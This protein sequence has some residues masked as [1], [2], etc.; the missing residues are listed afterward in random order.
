VKTRTATVTLTAW[1]RTDGYVRQVT[2]PRLMLRGQWLA[3][4]GFPEGTKV[5][6]EV[7]CGKLIIRRA[8]GE[9]RDE[10]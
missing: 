9:D 2:M 7:E 3:E 5:R 6:I 1:T 10:G 8:D 4:A